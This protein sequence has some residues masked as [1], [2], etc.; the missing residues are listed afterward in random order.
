M[1]D[2]ITGIEGDEISR[3]GILVIYFFS[4]ILVKAGWYRGHRSPKV[5]KL[6]WGEGS[7]ESD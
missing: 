2:L 7:E 6:S 5:L 1:R 3:V 4:R